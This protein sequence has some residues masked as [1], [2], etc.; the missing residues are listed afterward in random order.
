MSRGIH[1]GFSRTYVLN[2]ITPKTEGGS[3]ELANGQVGLFIDKTTKVGLQ[4]VDTVSNYKGAKFFLE[5][6][7][8]VGGNQGGMSTKGLRT[9]PFKAD[10]VIDI[11][12]DAAIAPTQAVTFIGFNGINNDSLSLKAGETSKISLRLTGDPI[13]YYGFK[14]GVYETEFTLSEM[15]EGGCDTSCDDKPC[16]DKVLEIVEVM[17]QRK[18]RDGL[19]L[20]DFLKIAAVTSCDDVAPTTTS[21]LFFCIEVCDAGDTNALALVQAQVSGYRVER[22]ERNGNTSKYQV[23]IT[24]GSE[25]PMDFEDWAVS[26][27][28]DCGDDCPTG[29]TAKA[30]GYL[31][32][33]SHEDDGV[34]VPIAGTVDTT[35][36]SSTRVGSS[37]GVGKYAVVLDGEITQADIDALVAAFP[38]I[39]I[40]MEHQVVDSVCIKNSVD[41]IPWEACGTCEVSEVAYSIELPD[42]ECG[43][44]RLAELT[45]YYPELTIKVGDDASDSSECRKRYYT[46]VPTNI[47]CDECYP[48]AFTSKPPS[49]YEFQEWTQ[50]ASATE[51]PADCKCGIRFEGREF[52]QCPDAKLADKI[53]TIV[54]QIEIQVSAGEL[55]NTLIGYENNSTPSE[56][57]RDSRAFNGSGWGFR[58]ANEERM[59]YD[60]HLGIV[61]SKDYAENTFKGIESKLDPCGM[62][63]VITLKVRRQLPSQSFSGNLVEY[64]RYKFVIPQGTAETFKPFFNAVASGNPNVGSI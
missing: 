55:T 1:S 17:K 64:F 56:Q 43:D 63:D 29:Y 23:V 30:G 59:S 25:A 33:M 50:V 15:Y 3:L 10:D 31:Y 19:R 38:T 52:E 27:K 46:K 16:R 34:D 13:A 18:V 60:Y 24:D 53:G 51:A 6:G 2:P 41:T 44:S 57:T 32:S 26:I 48:E 47:V 58:F 28:T 7:T 37:Y 5:V 12:Y 4:A 20:G 45:K 61:S 39:K 54:G 62:Y 35:V 49:P 9:A 8:G 21:A 11:T 36:V 40:D 14:G 22:V 42:T